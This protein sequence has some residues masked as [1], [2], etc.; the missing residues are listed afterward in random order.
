MG[1]GRSRNHRDN[2]SDLKGKVCPPLTEATFNNLRK[3]YNNEM[4]GVGRID[5]QGFERIITHVNQSIDTK[6]LKV[7][8]LYFCSLRILEYFYNSNFMF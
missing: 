1:Q 8:L 4:D 2:Y 5:Q 3:A 6:K 7:I